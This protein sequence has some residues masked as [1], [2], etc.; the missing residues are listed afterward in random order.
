M[1][2]GYMPAHEAAYKSMLEQVGLAGL[3]I[4]GNIYSYNMMSYFITCN[5]REYVAKYCIHVEK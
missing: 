5:P 1:H 2:S 4:A 3:K